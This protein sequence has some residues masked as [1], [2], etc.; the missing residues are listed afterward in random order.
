MKN[1]IQ[2][3]HLSVRP[4]HSFIQS[5]PSIFDRT[6][7]RAS[8]VNIFLL[9]VASVSHPVNLYRCQKLRPTSLG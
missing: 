1:R 9:V 4:F 3:L 6:P 5:D 7:S 2:D 8:M